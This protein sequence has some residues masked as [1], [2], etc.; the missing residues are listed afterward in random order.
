MSGYR[1]VCQ[2]E[3]HQKLAQFFPNKNIIFIA[4]IKACHV[5]M[6][7]INIIPHFQVNEMSCKFSSP[8]VKISII[9]YCFEKKTE[10]LSKTVDGNLSE[11]SQRIFFSFES[12]IVVTAVSF[13][14]ILIAVDVGVSHPQVYYRNFGCPEFNQHETVHLPHP[15]CNKYLTCLSKSVLLQSCPSSLHWN[16]EKNMCDYPSEAKC[17]NDVAYYDRISRRS[18]FK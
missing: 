12:F 11:N 9:L 17:V 6:P 1:T 18:R 2:W 8:W 10:N 3:H 13:I 16:I 14:I 4:S 15:I 7:V 5:W